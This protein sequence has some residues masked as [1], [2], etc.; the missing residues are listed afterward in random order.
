MAI[1]CVEWFHGSSHFHTL[2]HEAY[3][4]LRFKLPEPYANPS[5]YSPP[6]LIEYGFIYPIFYLLKG[7]YIL[8]TA[9]PAQ[10]VWR[11]LRQTSCTCP[12]Q[13][14]HSTTGNVNP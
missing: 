14:G 10:S 12:E 11:P 8:S 7:D 6:S 4:G 9:H 1:I 3:K 2:V 13:P 5:T